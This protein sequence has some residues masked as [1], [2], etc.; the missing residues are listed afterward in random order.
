MRPTRRFLALGLL[1]AACVQAQV[2]AAPST[3]AATDPAP[4]STAAE[5][6][7]PAV[8]FDRIV[9]TATRTGRAV[10]DVPNTVDVIDRERMDDT[11]VRD[12]EDLFRYEPGITVTRGFGRFGIGDIRIRGLGGNRVRIQTDGIAVPDAFLIGSFSNA[13]R[14]FVDLDTL[15][16][17]EVVR[18]PGSSLYGSDALGG[19]VAF[20]TRDPA[21]YLADGRDRHVGFRI[22]YESDWNGLSGG[23]NFASGGERWS[24]LVAVGHRQGTEPGN[25]GRVGGEGAARTLPNPQERDGRSLLAK[26]VFEPAAVQ[27]FRLAVEGNEDR[28]G[29]E[30]LTAR[31]PQGLT[32]AINDRVAASDHQTRARVSFGHEVDATGIAFVDS[33]DWQVYRQDSATT[34]Y[35]VE[36][37]TLPAPTFVDIRERTFDFDQRV[38]GL[39]LN[40]RSGFV[41]GRVRHDLAWG[42]D[43]SRTRTRQKRD[44]LRTFPLTGVETPAMLPDVFPARDFPN[45]RT[46]SAALYLQDE[47]TRRRLHPGVRLLAGDLGLLGAGARPLG[48]LPRRRPGPAPGGRHR[49]HGADHAAVHLGRGGRGGRRSRRRGDRCRLRPVGGGGRR[50]SGRRRRAGLTAPDGHPTGHSRRGGPVY[51][52]NHCMGRVSECPEAPSS[53][54]S[55]RSRSSSSS[56]RWSASCRRATSG[57]SNASASTR[58]RCRPACT[59]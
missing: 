50:R 34:Q 18:G 39:Q 20:V 43:V 17:V 41:T 27:R 42:L 7:A 59:C 11:I 51:T 28:A 58:T 5:A 12:L 9:V 2:H 8:E 23:A 52:R 22:G 47:I 49:R 36:Q 53:P 19:V 37:R 54:S 13:N 32:G 10:A 6:D 48:G 14:N 33:L 29:T 21:D 25:Q 40:L 31:G 45:S 1:L 3:P 44:G 55:W 26:L 16:R 38:H 57:P 46:T 35:T 15:K 24:G 30:M 56:S 4:A